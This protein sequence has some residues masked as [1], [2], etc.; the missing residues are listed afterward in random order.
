MTQEV[1]RNVYNIPAWRPFAKTLAS[2]LLQQTEGVPEK[3]TSYHLLL[4]T[5]RTCRVMCETFLAMNDGKA[6]LLPQLTITA[7]N[8]S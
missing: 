4:P 5:R 6:L 1:I 8:I 3:L 7:L 2:Y